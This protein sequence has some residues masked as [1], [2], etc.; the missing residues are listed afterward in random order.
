M[1]EGGGS[2]QTPS[3]QV[4]SGLG[5]HQSTVGSWGAGADL[6]IFPVMW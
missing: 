5:V 4:W 1:W 3:A 2:V 6:L